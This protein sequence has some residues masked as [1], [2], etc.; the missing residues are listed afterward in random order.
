[1]QYR[2]STTTS[3]LKASSQYNASGASVVNVTGNSIFSL[4]SN[5]IPDVKFLDNL[6]G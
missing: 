5:A 1:M 3:S 6:I 4:E 2:H